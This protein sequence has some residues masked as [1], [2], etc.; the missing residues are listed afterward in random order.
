MLADK[1][2]KEWLEKLKPGDEAYISQSYGAA[3]LIAKISRLTPTRIMAKTDVSSNHEYQ[4]H[5]KNGYEVGRD[6]WNNQHLIM[7][8]DAIRA[9]V[10]LEN[11]N[12]RAM[13]LKDKLSIPQTKEELQLFIETLSKLVKI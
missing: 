7:P 13:R 5:K 3:P 12:R 6:R 9:R 8:T 11:L 2:E 10:E 4:F 1:Y